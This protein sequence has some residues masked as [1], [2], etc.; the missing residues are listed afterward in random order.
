MSEEEKRVEELVKEWIKKLEPEYYKSLELGKSKPAYREL[1]NRFE[2]RYYFFMGLALGI[3]FGLLG[4]FLATH[5]IELLKSI[6]QSQQDWIT[7]NLV[8]VFIF[9]SAIAVCVFWINKRLRSDRKTINN[10]WLEIVTE[11]LF[12]THVPMPEELK[13]LLKKK[14]QKTEEEKAR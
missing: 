3:L 5:W 11:S 12:E 1:L 7:A 8:F 9:L 4:N 10:A 2:N 13:Q 14:E 6:I